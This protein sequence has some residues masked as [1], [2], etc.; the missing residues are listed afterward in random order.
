MAT[1]KEKSEIF[2]ALHE[3][4]GAFIIPNPWDIGSARLLQRIKV[5]CVLVEGDEAQDH[6]I[7]RLSSVK[8]PGQVAFI[9][10]ENQ[11]A[12]PRLAGSC[13]ERRCLPV[14]FQR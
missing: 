12:E 7:L 11:G 13:H 3:R 5:D 10:Y 1:H 14:S 4:E 6:C 8:R 9:T 2:K